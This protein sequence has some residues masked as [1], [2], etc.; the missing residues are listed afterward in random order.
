[1][2]L[3]V[4]CGSN[5]KKQQKQ[6]RL[7]LEIGSSQLAKGFYPAALKSLQESLRLDD[8]N[9]VT[10]NNLGLA[11]YV[12]DRYDKAEF[13][14]LKALELKPDYTEARNNLGRVYIAKYEFKKAIF[15]LK[16]AVEDLTYTA[17]EKSHSN[18]GYA[19]FKSKQYDQALIHLKNSLMIRRNRCFTNTIYGQ[20]LF[21]LKK[22]DLAIDTLLSSVDLC[23]NDVQLK[24]QAKFYASLGY[25]KK[26]Q[27]REATAILDEIV[28]E[29][30][31]SDYLNNAKKILKTL[32]ESH[33]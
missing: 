8:Q 27:T 18:L 30:H 32:S 11:Y 1:M 20:T 5:L 29:N 4:G 2:T 22:V 21:E 10:Y 13:Y 17:P 25:L 15:H 16:L 14:I 26:G 6:A 33:K 23:K 3:V 28:F 24:Q 9:P 19:Y 31:E 7:L 12:R